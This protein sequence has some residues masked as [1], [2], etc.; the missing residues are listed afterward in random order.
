MGNSNKT[1]KIK[2]TRTKQ[3]GERKKTKPKERSAHRY[4]GVDKLKC[5]EI[6]QKHKIGMYSIS[7]RPV[8]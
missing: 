3:I 2:Q 5:T 6:P 7:K 4:I 1:V 8:G